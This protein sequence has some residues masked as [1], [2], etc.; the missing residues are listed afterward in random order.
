MTLFEILKWNYP[1]LSRIIDELQT[2]W[3]HLHPLLNKLP[4]RVKVEGNAI[5]T[6]GPIAVVTALPEIISHLILLIF[7]SKREIDFHYFILQSSRFNNIIQ[8]YDKNHEP[9]VQAHFPKSQGLL[10][11]F[12]RKNNPLANSSEKWANSSTSHSNH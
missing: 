9:N 7:C 5:P 4:K 8:F 1:I 3:F 12:K 10:P 6:W 2:K 11:H